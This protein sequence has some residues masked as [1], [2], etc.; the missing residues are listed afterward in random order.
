M[1][2]KDLDRHEFQELV[3]LEFLLK[4]GIS[5]RKELAYELF[6][7]EKHIKLNK[8][9]KIES[10]E[11]SLIQTVIERCVERGYIKL[12]ID[13]KGNPIKGSYELTGFGKSVIKTKLMIQK[14]IREEFSVEDLHTDLHNSFYAYD[15]EFLAITL[16]IQNKE[17]VDIISKL[18]KNMDNLKEKFTSMV[19]SIDATLR[20][21]IHES[22]D[23]IIEIF[24]PEISQRI[25]ELKEEIKRLKEEISP[26]KRS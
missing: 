2:K 3:I 15:G 23:K 24:M 5:T 25:K 13:N 7:E 8:Y 16:L 19:S 9:P 6:S 21:D 10:Y 11:S 22:E 12:H 1:P 26:N 20:Y 4:K 14:K 17:L 18:E